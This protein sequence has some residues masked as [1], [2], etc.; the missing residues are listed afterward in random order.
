MKLI[1]RN[2]NVGPIMGG[3]TNR[4]R[5]RKTCGTVCRNSGYVLHSWGYRQLIN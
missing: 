1:V 4:K 3:E 2:V 5:R